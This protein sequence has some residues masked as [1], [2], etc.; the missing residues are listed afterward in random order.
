MQKH[1]D[2]VTILLAHVL[3]NAM[4]NVTSE[5]NSGAGRKGLRVE[6]ASL[7]E[8]QPATGLISVTT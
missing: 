8:R 4:R 7:L 1:V 2:G 3:L 6:L 5:D